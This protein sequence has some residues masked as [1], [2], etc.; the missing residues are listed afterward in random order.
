M[1][2]V[3]LP[4]LLLGAQRR[5]ALHEREAVRVVGAERQRLGLARVDRVGLAV[6]VEVEAGDEEVLVERG[7]GALV[8][9]RAVRRLGR[10]RRSAS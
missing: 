3:V 7:V 10:P 9:E 2:V 1:P 4:A 5:V 8:D 6:D